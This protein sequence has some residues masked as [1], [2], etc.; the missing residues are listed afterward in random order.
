MYPKGS[1]IL[2][3][4]IEDIPVEVREVIDNK[5]QVRIDTISR[6]RFQQKVKQIRRQ[7]VFTGEIELVSIGLED[8]GDSE[9]TIQIQLRVGDETMTKA[10][11]SGCYENIRESAENLFTLL[12]N[13]KSF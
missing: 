1:P 6:T 8:L 7:N 4:V 3:E 13:L 11:C 12:S 9:K 5:V 10:V 2:E